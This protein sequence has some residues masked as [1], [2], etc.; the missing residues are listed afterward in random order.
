LAEISSQQ[1]RARPEAA[2]SGRTA[3]ARLGI[4]SRAQDYR[5]VCYIIAGLGVIVRLVVYLR[6]GSIWADEAMLIFNVLD[7]SYRQLWGPLDF[8]QA[9]PP[10]FLWLTKMAVAAF[11]DHALVWRA[12]PFLASC[13]ALLVFVPLACDALSGFPAIIATLL[14]AFSDRILLHT[15]EVKPYTFDL[16]GAVVVLAIYCRTNSWPLLRQIVLYT[17]LAPLLVFSSYPSIFMLAGLFI[18]I[19]WRAAYHPAARILIAFLAMVSVALAAFLALFFGPIRAQD[20][21]PLHEYWKMHFPDYTKST[22]VLSWPFSSTFE[23]FRYAVSPDGGLLAPVALVGALSLW[24]SL[25]RQLLILLIFPMLAGMAAGFFG[26]YVWGHARIDLYAAPAMIL[27][28]A[29]GLGPIIQWCRAR[30]M[31][32]QWGVISILIVLFAMPVCQSLQHLRK[33]WWWRTEQSQEASAYVISHLQP[34]DRIATNQVEFGYYFGRARSDL[35]N[36][37]TAANTAA[38]RLWVLTSGKTL[39][40]QEAVV[41]PLLSRG[42]RMRMRKEF[43]FATVHLLVRKPPQPVPSP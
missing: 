22:S 31:L 17:V 11:G 38:S 24:N 29:A 35:S 7:K 13:A 10:A 39:P 23:A 26:R 6:G 15:A 14:F 37:N 16:L 21:G 25:Q 34:G 43:A 9:A 19:A 1:N 28:I 33:P 5:R 20:L 32:V 42:W 8:Y 4:V 12:L 30:N 36:V 3:A 27:L 40:E 41:A 2:V 18:L